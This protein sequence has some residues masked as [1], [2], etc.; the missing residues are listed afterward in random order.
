MLTIRFLKI[1][2][3]GVT[4]KEAPRYS[5]SMRFSRIWAIADGSSWE[6]AFSRAAVSFEEQLWAFVAHQ[7]K[8]NMLDLTEEVK[9]V[10]KEVREMFQLV[11][12]TQFVTG[13]EKPDASAS[14]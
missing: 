5:V 7:K 2:G 1:G 10:L 3:F 13:K 12:R 9:T 14:S 6:N 8:A 11:S 4:E